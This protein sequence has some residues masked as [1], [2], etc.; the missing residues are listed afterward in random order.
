MLRMKRKLRER[1]ND[2]K[3]RVASIKRLNAKP[4]IK[5]VDIEAIKATFKTAEAQN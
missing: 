3:S 5:N 2:S 4:V 1:R